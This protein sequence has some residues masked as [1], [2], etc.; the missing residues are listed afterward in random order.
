MH[1]N[2]PNGQLNKAGGYIADIF[3][4]VDVIYQNGI[5]GTTL[6]EKGT[7][8]GGS[9]EVYLTAKDAEKRNAYLSSFDGGILSSGSHKVI[10]T[11]VVR[12]ADSLTASLQNI[13]ESNIEKILTGSSEALVSM[14]TYLIEIA[15]QVA[16]D[17]KLSEYETATKLIELGYPLEKAEQ[18]AKNCGV[19][20]NNIAKGLAEGYA[21]YYAMVSPLMIAEL[22]ADHEFSSDNISYAIQ[23]ATIDWEFYATRHAE[24]FVSIVESQHEYLT[25]NAVLVYLCWEK[26]YIYDWDDYVFDKSE[27]CEIALNNLD[28]NWNQKALEYIMRFMVVLSCQTSHCQK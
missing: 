24:E 14:D 7:D 18:I 28:V 2:D 13:L 27:Y 22:L 11:C 1:Y 8:A 12:T 16:E 4:S 19:N 15:K 9:I 5:P 3:F 21:D 20:W 26:G 17:E 25:P 6:V 23:N 10:G